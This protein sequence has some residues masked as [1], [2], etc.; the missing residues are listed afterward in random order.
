MNQIV[1]MFMESNKRMEKILKGKVKIDEIAAA[2]R[3]FEGQIK[4]LNTVVSAF[5]IASK[6][7]RA[8]S[9]MKNMNLM[10]DST[11]VDLMLGDVELD[12]IKCPLSG[13]IITRAECLDYSGSKEHTDECMNCETGTDTKNKLLGERWE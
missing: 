1:K 3:E 2:Q 12:K 4:L 9:G 11:A 7:K 6:N 10:D 13:Q 5:G 8:L